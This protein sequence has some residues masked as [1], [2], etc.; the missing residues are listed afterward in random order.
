MQSEPPRR[1][2]AIISTYDELCGIAGYTRALEKQLAPY[3]DLK[4]F[5]LDQYL[6]RSKHKRVQKLA[7]AHIQ[8]I[9]ASLH[10]F[11]C[12]NIQLEHGTLGRE[13][14]DIIRRF[15]MLANAAPALSVTMHTVMIN[16]GLPYEVLGRFF[17]QG[18]LAAM[19]KIIAMTIKAERKSR[20]LHRLLHRLQ[21]KK[22]ISVIVH[23][24]R[25]MR[26]IR[27]IFQIKNMYHHP[28]SFISRDDAIAVRQRTGRAN[29]PLIESLPADAKLIG[30]F[31]LPLRL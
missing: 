20:G 8:E 12:V 2:I 28:L 23:T 18:R 14:S 22:P 19:A 10:K 1:R 21:D 9:A 13:S 25:D 7:D 5:D 3:A 11:D 30:T 4:I 31:R 26:M 6:L 17:K 24:K 16:E 27:D 15:R 29:F